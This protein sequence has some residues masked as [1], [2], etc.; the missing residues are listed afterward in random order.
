MKWN[1]GSLWEYEDPIN[2]FYL[3]MHV[4]EGRERERERDIKWW[5]MLMG[6]NFKRMANHASFNGTCRQT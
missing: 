5:R 3:K 4:C 6:M 2:E 1:F